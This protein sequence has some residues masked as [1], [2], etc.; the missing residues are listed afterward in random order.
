LPAAQIRKLLYSLWRR[1]Y[2]IAQPLSDPAFRRMLADLEGR[3][4]I[5]EIRLA[6][7]PAR[8]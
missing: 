7:L 4:F 8:A 1:T 2:R 6:D 5:G 3:P